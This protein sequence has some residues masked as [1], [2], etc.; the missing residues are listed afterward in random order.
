MLSS[1]FLGTQQPTLWLQCRRQTRSFFVQ[2][3]FLTIK[4]GQSESRRKERSTAVLLEVPSWDGRP[5]PSPSALLGKGVT[6]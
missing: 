3:D 2:L 1:S 4:L 6:R 5:G